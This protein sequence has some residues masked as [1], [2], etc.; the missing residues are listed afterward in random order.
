MVR[1][2]SSSVRMVRENPACFISSPDS[3]FLNQD[4]YRLTTARSMRE[5]RGSRSRQKSAISGLSSRIM[6]FFPTSRSLKTSHSVSGEEKSPILNFVRGLRNTS[7]SFLS[8]RYQV[9]GG[10]SFLEANARE[11]PW[12]GLLSLNPHSSYS[13]SRSVL[14]MQWPRRI[15]GRNSEPM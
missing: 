13:M 14:L 9:S 12:H 5:A 1:R 11:R 6:P 10:T 2:L 15:C 7:P 8:I 3:W 4:V